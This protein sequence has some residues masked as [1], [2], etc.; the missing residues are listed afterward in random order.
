MRRVIPLVLDDDVPEAILD[1]IAKAN[2]RDLDVRQKK[3][4]ALEEL[5]HS[6]RIREQFFWSLACQSSFEGLVAQLFKAFPEDPWV[7]ALHD[8]VHSSTAQTGGDAS[9][10]VG[11][12]QSAE[13]GIGRGVS[14]EVMETLGL[15]MLWQDEAVRTEVG[16]RTLRKFMEARGEEAEQAREQAKQA[17]LDLLR[18]EDLID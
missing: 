11:L 12:L 1:W 18:R 3:E 5:L 9:G 16:E 17:A 10:L 13:V 7:Q 15:E 4:G 2:L 8:E 14:Q 6:R